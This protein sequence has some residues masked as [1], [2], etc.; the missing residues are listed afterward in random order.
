[1]KYTLKKTRTCFK[2]SINH[3]VHED[4]EVKPMVFHRNF[5]SLCVL[6]ALCGKSL[7]FEMASSL[8][9]AGFLSLGLLAPALADDATPAATIDFKATVLPILQNSCFACH[10]SGTKVTLPADP[11]LAKKA[12]NQMDRAV[13]RFA[14]GGSFPFPNDQSPAKQIAHMQKVISKGFMPP[15]S[16]AK[17]GLG[18]PLSAQDRSTLLAWLAQLQNAPK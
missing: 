12:Q 18:S 4:H 7:G 16:Q 11:A 6:R 2:T 13:E 3:E 15:K 8:L 9:A 5:D 14:M 1:M 10:V 17:L